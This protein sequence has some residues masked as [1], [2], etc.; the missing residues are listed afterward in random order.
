MKLSLIFLTM[1][2]AVTGT[3]QAQSNSDY[4]DFGLVGILQHP[5][6]PVS[7][8]NL[9]YILVYSYTARYYSEPID[10]NSLNITFDDMDALSEPRQPLSDDN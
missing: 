5:Q 9:A 1:L 2:F 4:Q 8:L 10:I 7:F 3:A 6:R